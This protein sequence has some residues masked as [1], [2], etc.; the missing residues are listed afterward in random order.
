VI[1]GGNGKDVLRGGAGRDELY[2]GNG[3]DVFIIASPCEVRAGEIIDGGNG[4]DRIESP[5]TREQLEQRGVVIRN[6]EEF[7]VTPILVDAECAEP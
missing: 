7:V 4:V 5:L 3:P 6:V 2:G 1:R